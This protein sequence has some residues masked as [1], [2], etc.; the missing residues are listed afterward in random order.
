MRTHLEETINPNTDHALWQYMLDH[1]RIQPNGYHGIQLYFKDKSDFWRRVQA[2][3]DGFKRYDI[4]EK[5]KVA[6]KKQVE[7]D[8]FWVMKRIAERNGKTAK[9]IDKQGSLKEK[10][11]LWLYRKTKKKIFK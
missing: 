4:E 8:T 2:R 3:Y 10:A 9:R 6:A 1:S 7:W 11:T 5:E